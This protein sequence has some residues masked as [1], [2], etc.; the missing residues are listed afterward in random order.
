MDGIEV[1]LKKYSFR[2]TKDGNIFAYAVDPSLTPDKMMTDPIGTTYGVVLVEVDENDQPVEKVKPK[3]HEMKRS[4]QAG[5]LC[6]DPSLLAG[7]RVTV[8]T[9]T[10]QDGSVSSVG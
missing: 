5:I 1:F 2:Q 7:P 4:Q 8:P 6:N 10:R 9:Q 3:F